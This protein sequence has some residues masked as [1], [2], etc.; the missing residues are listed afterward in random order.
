MKYT[1]FKFKAKNSP[2]VLSHRFSNCIQ[3]AITFQ[4]W[5]WASAYE[6]PRL[7]LPRWLRKTIKLQTS[8]VGARIPNKFGIQMVGVCSV[9]EWSASLCSVFEWSGPFEIRTMASLGRFI[10]INFFSL[11]IK[12]PC[13]ERPFWKFGFGMV[14]TIRKP[15]KMAAILFFYHSK[16]EH[17]KVRISN[18]FGIRMFGIRALTVLS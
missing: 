10:Y 11:F 16:S 14:R 6:N 2:L 3:N 5:G 13:L 15:N 18:G 8:T 1:N 7:L 4:R 17:K 9:F 12:Q